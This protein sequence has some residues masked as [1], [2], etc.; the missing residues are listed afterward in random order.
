MKMMALGLIIFLFAIAVATF[1]ESIYN[2]Q[3][4]KLI[5]YN[6]IW[7]ELLLVYLGISLFVNIYR[8]QMWKREKIAML[9]FH[10]SFIVILIGAGITRYISFEGI[11]KLPEPDAKTG[12]LRPIDHIYSADPRLKIFI[13]NKYVEETMYLSEQVKTRF[14]VDF[15]FPEKG[16]TINVELVNFQSKHI[17]SLIV[18]DTITNYVIDIVTGGKESNY[19][20]EGEFMMIGD[21]PLSFSKKDL[22]PGGIEIYKVNGKMMLK[23]GVPMKY[24]PMAQMQKIRQSGMDVPDSLFINIPVDTLVPFNITTLYY[25]NEESFVFKEI[26]N[27][28]K[29]MRVPSGRK[30]VGEDFI[31]LKI[32]D[33][34]DVKFVTVTGGQGVIATEE[35]FTFNEMLYSIQYGSVP[36]RLPFSLACNEFTL[37]KYPGSSSPSSY[38]SIVTVIDNRNNVQKTQKIFMN[39]VMDYDGYRFFQSS[40]FP[41]ETGTILSVNHDWWG[42]TI[43]YIGYLMMSIGMLLSL[44]A[45]VGRF[46][47]VN[48]KLKKIASKRAKDG[49]AIALI[50]LSTGFSFTQEEQDYHVHSDGTKH[51]G[52]HEDEHEHGHEHDTHQNTAVATQNKK[53]KALYISNEHSEKLAHLM[54]L[55]FDGRIVPLHTICDELLRKIHRSDKFEDNGVT[56]NAIQTIFSMHM[57]GEAWISKKIIYVSSVLRDSF[58]LKGAYASYED[59]MDFESDEFKLS[60][61]YE[62][63]HRKLD[64]EKSEADKQLIKLVERLEVVRQTINWSYM[65]I[66][67]IEGHINN[68]WVSPLLVTET[69]GV[70]KELINATMDYYI[71]VFSAM[72]SGNY[73]DADKLLE[74]LMKMQRAKA[75]NKIPSV[76]K[77]KIEVSYNKMHVF[78]NAQNLYL[79]L[80]FVLLLIFFFRILLGKQKDSKAIRI[81]KVIFTILIGITFIYHGSGLGMRWYISGHAPWSNGYEA[82]VFIAWVTIL[83]GFIFSKKNPAILAATAILAFFMLFVTEMN[84]LDPEITPLVPVLKSYWL[85]IHVAIITGSYAFLGLGAILGL[86]NLLL[87]I[88][89]TQKNGKLITTNINELTYVSEMTMTIGLFMLTIGTFLGGVWANESWGR[90]WGWDPKETWAL[91]SVL[92]YAVVL[93][94]R[95]IPALKGKFVFNVVSFWSYSAILFTF[96]GVNFYLVGLHSYAQGDGLGEFPFGVVIATVVFY[97]FTE[98]AAL[99][100]KRYTTEAKEINLTYFIKKSV[101]TSVVFVIIYVS[102]LLLHV[103][104]SNEC[105]DISWK[106]VALIF[107]TNLILFVYQLILPNKPVKLADSE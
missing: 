9:M 49:L 36:I 84:I 3:T 68:D 1:L 81:V 44:F 51:Y 26:I 8:Y 62:I 30:D 80:G 5:I 40:Y 25:V 98:F 10:L 16:K 52:T 70:D 6:A 57:T 14:N 77:I 95:F 69:T 38:E 18:N 92:V 46:K 59:L 65:R 15:K 58:N 33:G 13:E 28:A 42:T 43:T 96:F 55:D 31:T 35:R 72:N 74:N 100:N 101:I 48:E 104:E 12:I 86:V 47:E 39:N 37:N 91:V 107:A 89:R 34:K 78:K 85:M 90:Y 83:A 45:P 20:S 66:L 103:I 75:D 93:H 71:K 11:M 54:V 23:T 87:Y 67:P 22:M 21:I 24:L 41:D 19:L 106:T 4:A 102:F 73:S 82:V 99:K 60:K 97:F 53:L 79:T 17:D 88:F 76:S 29:M 94:L 7:F 63:A 64:K 27:H 2:I 56:Y 61:S 32:T 50:L 105:I